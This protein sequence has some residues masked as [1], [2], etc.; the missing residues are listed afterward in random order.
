LPGSLAFSS[1]FSFS[2]LLFLP[3][4]SS[5]LTAPFSPP[6]Q[7]LVGFF[8]TS[9]L[10]LPAPLVPVQLLCAAEEIPAPLML[11]PVARA[12]MLSPEMILFKSSLSIYSPPFFWSILL[13]V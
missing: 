2:S 4:S 10:T 9:S 6:V 5:V 11:I 3:F 7:L 12:T 13:K 8:W 1:F